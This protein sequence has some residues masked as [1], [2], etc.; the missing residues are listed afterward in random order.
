MRNEMKKGKKPKSS[1]KEGVNWNWMQEIHTKCVDLVEATHNETR[2][3]LRILRT[4]T[5][6]TV[7]TPLSSLD[8]SRLRKKSAR[9]RK[10]QRT[11]EPRSEADDDENMS[12]VALEVPWRQG[13][14]KAAARH[15]RPTARAPCCVSYLLFTTIATSSKIYCSS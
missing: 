13:W 9:G 10:R 11:R 7:M 4:L 12:T 3:N 5:M 2:R 15:C 6:N 8:K 14:Q 1:L